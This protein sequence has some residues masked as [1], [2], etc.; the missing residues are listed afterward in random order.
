MKQNVT[1]GICGKSTVAPFT[2]AWIETK[3][4]IRRHYETFVAPFTGAWIETG[5]KAYDIMYYWVAPFTGAWIETS[6]PAKI[7]N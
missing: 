6:Y 4:K 2:G 3:D 7:Q 1:T 5:N